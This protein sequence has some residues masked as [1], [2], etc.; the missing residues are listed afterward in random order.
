MAVKFSD[1]LEGYEYTNFDTGGI[2]QAFLDKETGK[3]YYYTDSGDNFE[4][5]PE[6]L[7][8]SDKYIEIPCKND[9][10][11]GRN[12]VFDFAVQHLPDDANY[13]QDMFRRKGAYSQFR[14]FL[15]HKGAI[16]KWY[17]FEN[18]QVEKA[19]REWC[20]LYG[21]ELVD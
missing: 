15:E 11:L 7:D 2:N 16:K 20:A 17:D 19:L 4:E 18:E 9:L 12:L 13:I 21:V 6:D 5:L 14:N 10:D 1:V 3:V 8:E